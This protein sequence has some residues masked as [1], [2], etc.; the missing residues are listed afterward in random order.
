MA[1]REL[2]KVYYQDREAYENLYQMRL[3][4]ENTKV[5]DIK[6]HN[7]PAF[8]CLCEDIYQLTFQIMELDKK[9]QVL[10]KSLPGVALIQFAN[11]CLID[12]IHLSNDIEHV[13]STREEIRQ[14]TQ[15]IKESKQRKNGRFY[16]L[17]TKYQML[18]RNKIEIQT[19]ED[20]RKLYDELVLPEIMKDDPQK[21]PDGKVFRRELAEVT[22]ET[23][24][25][26]HKG[27]YPEEKIIDY[28]E[29]ALNILKDESL[30]IF[31]RISIFHYLFGYIH[32]FYDG[33]G[34]TSRFISSYL[35][36]D[37]AGELIGY[38]LSYTIKQNIS[39]YYEAFKVCNNERN[40]GDLTP[41]IITFLEII[42]KAFEK[43]Y[44][45]L[46]ERNEVLK[47]IRQTMQ[48]K[49]CFADNGI[50]RTGDFLAQAALFSK[51][52]ISKKELGDLLKIS[53]TTLR[54][55][56]DFLKQEGL[57]L[58]QRVGKYKYYVLDIT[59]LSKE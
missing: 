33:N 46:Y 38:R 13:D 8:Y 16:G 11:K 40:R 25:V 10:K 29:R 7:Y 50:R 30:P 28:M 59:A 32:P 17:I 21:A 6:I 52:G 31:V 26:I 39:Q 20:I 55:R 19:C 57:L 37:I 5:L 48:N 18:G 49:P 42:C 9:V 56:L 58:E 12:E 4:S 14:A 1:Y 47:E 34:R 45:A 53:E 23:Q 27:V 35:L 36:S 24:K 51:E 54:K 15:E 22:T 2:T 3:S 41:F 44:E 43:L